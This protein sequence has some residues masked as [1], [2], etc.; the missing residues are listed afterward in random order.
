[1]PSSH[2][3]KAEEYSRDRHPDPHEVAV[4]DRNRQTSHTSALCGQQPRKA[5][6]SRG[7]AVLRADTPKTETYIHTN[8]KSLPSLETPTE[9]YLNRAVQANHTNYYILY[10]QTNLCYS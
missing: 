7:A 1:M 9:A 3:C 5:H 2:H 6:M 4:S 10:T 8:R